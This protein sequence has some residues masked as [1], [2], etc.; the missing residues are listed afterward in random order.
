MLEKITFKQKLVLECIE[1]FIEEYGYSPT[2]R[3]LADILHCDI[4]TVYKKVVALMYKGYVTSTN[5][6]FRTLQVV[7]N[8]KC[9]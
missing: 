9:R 6:K 3:E 7:K 8:D 4:N 2:Y 5:G 1:N